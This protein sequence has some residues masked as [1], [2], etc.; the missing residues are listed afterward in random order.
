MVCQRND[1]VHVDRATVLPYKY[2]HDR[3]R[4]VL[5]TVQHE[6][7]VRALAEFHVLHF[8]RHGGSDVERTIA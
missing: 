1:I 4:G 2:A 5:G 8:R 7:A 3:L 6:L